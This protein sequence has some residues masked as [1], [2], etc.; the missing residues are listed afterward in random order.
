MPD[1]HQMYEQLCFFHRSS[2]YSASQNTTLT[3]VTEAVLGYMGF[4]M[5]Y[6][7]Y[8]PAVR[9]STFVLPA[10]VPSLTDTILLCIQDLTLSLYQEPQH[11]VD[12]I[13][14]LVARNVGRG[15]TGKHISVAKKVLDFLDSRQQWV[16]LGAMTSCLS[17]YAILFYLFW[18]HAL[19]FFLTC[20]HVLGARSLSH[21]LPLLQ[22]PPQ[23]QELPSATIVWAWVDTL[24][25]LTKKKIDVDMAG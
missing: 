17:R 25:A 11:F 20:M 2:R 3:S 22:P 13:A 21:Q 4:L 9:A 12:F 1:V 23:P 16:H 6:K 18:L 10:P 24:L 19:S 5:K 8:L 14:Y 15:T 7:S